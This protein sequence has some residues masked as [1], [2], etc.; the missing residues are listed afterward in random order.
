[1]LDEKG[2][3]R[4]R[5]KFY[6]LIVIAII[7]FIV[8]YSLSLNVPPQQQDEYSFSGGTLSITPSALYV[9][10][11]LW[12]SPSALVTVSMI[13]NS[14]V[15]HVDVYQ[16]HNNQTA[17]FDGT[18]HNTSFFSFY[19]GLHPSGTSQNEN[20]IVSINGQPVPVSVAVETSPYPVI[21]EL[22]LL[23]SLVFLALGLYFA[24]FRSRSW[25][26][27]VALSYVVLSAFMGQRYDMFFIVS[28]GLHILSGVNPFIQS[29]NL[30]GTL[31]WTYPPYYLVWSVIADWF[32]GVISHTAVPSA[33]SLI[34]P[35]VLSGDYFDAWLG[36]VPRSLPLYYLLAKLPMVTSVLAIYALLQK[37]KLP[38]NLTK[39]WLLSPFVIL[40]GVVWG[41][42]DI[43]AS[44]FLVASVFYLQKGRTD[45][46]VLASVL[47]FWVKIFPIFILPFI[48]ITSK[49][50]LRDFGIA[51]AASLPA[52]L[53]YV[54]S[55]NFVKELEVILYS[56]ATNTFSGVFSAQG[57]SWQVILS[58]LGVLQFPSLFLYLFVPFFVTT[59]VV[60]FYRR[61][62]AVNYVIMNLLFFYLTYNYVDP[63]YLIVLVPL[64][65][66]NRDLWNYMVFSIYPFLFTVMAYSFSYFVVPS[67]SLNYFA[68]PLGQMEALRTW[69]T[70][71]NL[72]IFPFVIAFSISVVVTMI[73]VVENKRFSFLK[74]GMF[75][76]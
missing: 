62:N 71:S 10:N 74:G 68:S 51:V 41:Q 22:S 34:Y 57:L 11:F 67:L 37:F 31:K 27:P 26:I 38:Y 28:G 43:I 76:R 39:I 33:H 44:A 53:I 46:A 75:S 48:L 32:S 58:R 56:R 3:H 63:Q 8:A 13:S 15:V 59:I 65:L 42:L 24:P 70:S 4:Q 47:G 5:K 12:Y 7:L 23:F 73:K 64:F 60:Y 52:L 6:S 69:I 50:K 55:G 18:F 2:T 35:A 1:M 25:I 54:V 30:P 36:F 72:F 19:F 21:G 66:I 45:V 16:V 17:I 14:S 61:G 40:I 9:H 20:F 29:I 49:N